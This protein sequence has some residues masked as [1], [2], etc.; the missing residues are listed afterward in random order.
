MDEKCG[1][2]NENNSCR[3]AAKTK[4]CIEAGI[5]DPDHLRFNK[6][7]V[8]LVKHFVTENVDMVEDA[9]DNMLDLKV[10]STFRDQPLLHPPNFIPFLQLLLKRKHVDRIIDFDEDKKRA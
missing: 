2:I 6:D 10:Q 4:A 3:C 7:H 9:V 1:L 8:L 5:V